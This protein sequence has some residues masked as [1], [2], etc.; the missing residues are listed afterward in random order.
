[1]YIRDLQGIINKDKEDY[2]N[3]N[4]ILD[5]LDL[6]NHN[7]S[8]GV[9]YPVSSINPNY[10]VPSVYLNQKRS[11]GSFVPISNV[12]VINTN[13]NPLPLYNL[14]PNPN[15]NSNI[16]PNNNAHVNMMVSNSPQSKFYGSN[17]YGAI[18]PSEQSLKVNSA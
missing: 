5:G 3:N 12:N 10:V 2:G 11:V 1:M 9:N 7:V 4:R 13:P 8:Y 17:M 16:N 14:L 15:I 6:N 18:S